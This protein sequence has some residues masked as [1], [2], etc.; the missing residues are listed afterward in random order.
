MSEEDGWTFNIWMKMTQNYWKDIS[1][2]TKDKAQPF[3]LLEYTSGTNK[4]SPMERSN[5]F[6]HVTVPATRTWP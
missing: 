4:K 5:C 1:K 3:L 2:E 6:L